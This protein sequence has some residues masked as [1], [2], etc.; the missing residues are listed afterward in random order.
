MAYCGPRGIP[1]SVFLA[2]DH[3]DQD[4][5]LAWLH[6]DRARCSGCGTFADEWITDE[7]RVRIPPPFEPESVLCYGCQDVERYRKH[8]GDEPPLGMYVV[9]K[10]TDPNEYDSQFFTD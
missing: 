3:D 8:L 2:W 1:H 7:G 6:N 9:L 5:A 10:P 4:K